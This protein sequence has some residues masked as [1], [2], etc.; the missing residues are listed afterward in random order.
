VLETSPGVPRVDALT[1]TAQDWQG[2]ERDA[3]ARS[4]RVGGLAGRIA[5]WDRDA[6]HRRSLVVA[7]VL[8]ATIALL[9]ARIIGAL[10]VAPEH[11]ALRSLPLLAISIPLIVVVGKTVGMYDRDELVLRKST[12]DESS[13]IF[14]LSTLYA[15]ITWLINGFVAGTNGRRQ[16]VLIWL[17]LFAS[18]VLCRAGARMLA[19]RLTAPER[20]LVVGDALTAQRMQE[21]L[22]GRVSL[23]A[24]V[25]AQIQFSDLDHVRGGRGGI[26][27]ED[28]RSLVEQLAVDRIMVAPESSDGEE[29]LS[30]VR[31]ATLA[32]V[33]V[34]VVPRLL[35]VMGSSVEFDDVDG[36]TLL[37]VRRPR[38]GRSSRTAKRGLDL[39]GSLGALL[40][41]GPLMALVAMLVKLDSEGPVLFRQLRVGR[42]G[43]A[44]EILKFR[45]MIP[46]AELRKDE[47]RHLNEASGLFK[48]ADD[49]R[50]TPIGKLLRRTSLDELPQLWNV[51]RGDMSLVGPRPLVIDEDCRIA[52]WQRGRLQLTPGMTGHWQILGSARVP[53]EEMVKIDY[54]Y[55]THWSLWLDVKILL[56]TVPYVFSR[57]GM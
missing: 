16:L 14:E 19:R 39:A 43:R 1:A 30:L 37:A 12:L 42:D 25:I 44:F 10:G 13:V 51:V 9:A 7:D 24:T 41:L 5:G 48:I 8:A 6:V 45:T 4:V 33:K 31:A 32:G 2:I 23:H 54:L 56:R 57:R 29:V 38:L 52:G 15:L 22:E 21:K 53:L 17:G 46:D 28:L 27:S 49:P 3:Q 36:V 55:V 11:V 47:L 34:S 26:D 50:I 18:L 35:E 40:V 20:C